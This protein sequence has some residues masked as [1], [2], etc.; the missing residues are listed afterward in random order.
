MH[1][2]IFVTG[3]HATVAIAVL[4]E[5]IQYENIEII[6]IGRKYTSGNKKEISFEYDQIKK[7]GLQFFH[8]D[9][10]RITKRVD[11]NS[12]VQLYLFVSALIKSFIL[13]SKEK[14]QIIVS[15]GG[16]IALPV[17]IMAY[18]VNIPI[19]THEQTIRPG[20]ANVM[21][22]KLAKKILLSFPTSQKYF[23]NHKTIITGNP[24]RK[25]LLQE[26]KNPFNFSKEKP[27][28]YVTGGQLGAHSLNILIEEIIDQITPYFILV[29]QTGN[30]VKYQ[31]FER[32]KKRN[33]R[34]YYPA[35]HF[36]AAEVAYF[37]KHAN[38]VISRS[39][40]NSLFELYHFRKP[41]ILVPLP[42]S[43]R[44]EQSLQAEVFAKAGVAEVVDQ[45]KGSDF[46]MN[47]INKIAAN[48]LN[49]CNNYKNLNLIDPTLA[50]KKVA[51]EIYQLLNKSK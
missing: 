50:A 28:I 32:L 20:F 30:V 48:T 42:W 14:P 33:E 39:G 5:L 21:I 41:A 16:Y 44:D 37:L 34:N 17:C 38:F 19:V 24:I 49:Y 7:M 43:S 47:S 40:A 4:Q 35:P 45:A 46:L 31:D 36:S 27:L 1:K 2:K 29:H 13:I 18:F 10:G 15:F 51:S 11:W 12:I 8:L 6:F 22:A 23:D 3:G 9:S 26:G 25:E